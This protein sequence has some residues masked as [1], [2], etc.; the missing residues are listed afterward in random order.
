M[1]YIA[2]V[3]LFSALPFADADVILRG[4]VRS[5][6]GEPIA[7]ARVWLCRAG[8]EIG[9]EMTLVT[10]G[11]VGPDGSFEL[12][13]AD[14][15]PDNDD[16]TYGVYAYKEAWSLDGTYVDELDAPVPLR[17]ATPEPF[18]GR[19]VG[20]G[21]APVVGAR[22]RPRSFDRAAGPERSPICYLPPVIPIDVGADTDQSGDFTL[23]CLPSAAHACISIR[24]AGYG[25]VLTHS[26]SGRNIALEPAGSLQLRAVDVP[27]PAVVAGTGIDLRSGDAEA[28]VELGPAGTAD[29]PELPPGDYLVSA[30]HHPSTEYLVDGTTAAH[31]DSG[32]TRVAR[33]HVLKAAPVTGRVVKSDTG[34]PVSGC[35]VLVNTTGSTLR[36][37]V[38]PD[39]DGR[40]TVGGPLGRV[41]L[42]IYPPGSYRSAR[43]D[44][45]YVDAVVRPQGTD[46]GDIAL[47]RIY[48]VTV[49]ATD[50]AGQPVSGARITL[51][52]DWRDVGLFMESE[53]EPGLYECSRVKAGTH[54]LKATVHESKSGADPVETTVG[55]NTE[56][57]TIV[58][59]RGALVA[60]RARVVGTDGKPVEGVV[61]SLEP[62]D[63]ETPPR[64]TADEHGKVSWSDLPGDMRYK[65]TLDVPGLPAVVTPWWEAQPGE[66]HDFGDL[67]LKPYPGEVSGRTVGAD[68]EAIEGATVVAVTGRLAPRPYVSGREMP[69][70]PGPAGGP[71]DE[72]NQQGWGG[73]MDQPHLPASVVGSWRATTDAEGRL[74]IRG[75]PAGN[76]V[77]IAEA[78]GHAMVATVVAHD[79]RDVVLTLPQ[80]SEPTLGAPIPDP[81]TPVP[82]EAAR[83]L[84]RQV[85]DAA[86]A[87]TPDH[88][89]ETP[90]YWTRLDLLGTLMA[91]DPVAAIEQAGARSD[92]AWTLRAE[93]CVDA[94]TSGEID[95]DAAV[96]RL[97]ELA[98]QAGSG[99][100]FLS[101]AA[102]AEELVSEHPAVARTIAEG[103]LAHAAEAPSMPETLGAKSE[104]ARTLYLLG[105]PRAEGL[106]REVAAEAGRSDTRAKG[107]GYAH[108]AAAAAVCLIDVK[109]AFELVASTARNAV[110]VVPKERIARVAAQFPTEELLGVIDG[111]VHLLLR[112]AIV[113][114][115]ARRLATTD[116][117][118]VVPFLRRAEG[119][120]DGA[121]ERQRVPGLG[122][123]AGP[124]G[125]PLPVY[126]EEALAYGVPYL[127]ARS[128]ADALRAADSIRGERMRAKALIRLAQ[129]APEAEALPLFAKGVDLACEYATSDPWGGQL[130]AGGLLDL[131]A[132]LADVGYS[133]YERPALAG[134]RICRWDSP[135]GYDGWGDGRIL[136]PL[137]RT[138]PDLAGA[139]LENIISDMP[140]DE[141]SAGRQSW[142]DVTTAAAQVDPRWAAELLDHI[143]PPDP[144]HKTNWSADAADTVARALLRLGPQH[145]DLDYR[146]EVGWEVRTPGPEGG[147]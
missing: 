134:L 76:V 67:V 65:L 39:T 13:D 19:V 6:D 45:R 69:G 27:D 79:A 5:V 123:L 54:T 52:D 98:A 140:S 132:T 87:A 102:Y 36:T 24:A 136:T 41:E 103:A 71:G 107:S 7:D 70:R 118:A 15:D 47:E 8:P 86:L 130:G 32:K 89:R 72:S 105:D 90:D 109:A 55:E 34:E 113:E 112:S 131:S 121:D 38:R 23:G 141:V 146:R 57:V 42:S 50:D 30:V 145:G 74:T 78:P 35:L 125:P 26:E 84:A 85:L 142:R 115:H 20:E 73:E 129:E 25:T 139:L 77:L 21:G 95:D 104:A 64:A 81:R 46:L 147:R 108:W 16:V 82:D 53:D 59:R 122:V 18:I 117:D 91:L 12:R 40:F 137:A 1:R 33:L 56:P 144:D 92:V 9:P 66:S 116:P 44:S 3:L 63:P 94:L 58:I 100:P 60:I 97:K 99:V 127:A 120:G 126:A 68:G 75:L 106:V 22:V 11:R 111:P 4:D 83:A 133:G 14:L 110:P 2:A 31:V 135:P 62:T 88:G 138:R 37:S 10:E 101:L 51:W 119:H 124:G 61:V 48:T 80:A 128:F 93:Q 28:H 96:A 43:Y 49:R 114:A 17:L 29:L 143:R